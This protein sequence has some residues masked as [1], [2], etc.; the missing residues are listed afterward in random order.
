METMT[1]IAIT[2]PAHK[3]DRETHDKANEMVLMACAEAGFPVTSEWSPV[4]TRYEYRPVIPEDI[5]MKACK[6]VADALGMP[7]RIVEKEADDE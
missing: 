6:L 2:I 1:R 7:Y 4:L 3:L 5:W